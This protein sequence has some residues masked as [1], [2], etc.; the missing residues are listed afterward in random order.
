MLSPVWPPRPRIDLRECGRVPKESAPPDPTGKVDF[1]AWTREGQV[2]AVVIVGPYGVESA[3]T[4]RAVDW[5]LRALG[6]NRFFK[7]VALVLS[8][9]A[10]P[11]R[12][13]AFLGAVPD[14]HY[15]L[16]V[17]RDPL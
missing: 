2:A 1:F 6:L 5:S 8:P 10:D 7:F 11:A 4:Q 16:S 17:W 14:A 13:K 3:S 12:Y 15:G 9:G